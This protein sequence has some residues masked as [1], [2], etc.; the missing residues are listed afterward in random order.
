MNRLQSQL[1]PR[2]S[3]RRPFKGNFVAATA[4]ALEEAEAL[5]DDA[6]PLPGESSF[7]AY[8]PVCYHALPCGCPKKEATQAELTF[9]LADLL[10]EL[11]GGAA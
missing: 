1:L 8:C 6:D 7:S 10:V 5:Q 2:N 9:P 11:K 3:Y 4:A